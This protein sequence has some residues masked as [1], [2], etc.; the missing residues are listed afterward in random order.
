MYVDR[1]WMTMTRRTAGQKTAELTV[2]RV[3]SEMY[4]QR[5][6]LRKRRLESLVILVIY[7]VLDVAAT[8]LAKALRAIARRREAY[9]VWNNAASMDQS[10]PRR[11]RRGHA[12]ARGYVRLR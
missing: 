7:I 6:V 9:S 12:P 8:V 2:S 11:R 10:P 1:T 5:M 3:R 4:D